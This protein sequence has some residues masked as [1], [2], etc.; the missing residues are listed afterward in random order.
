[1]NGAMRKEFLHWIKQYQG[2]EGSLVILPMK[3]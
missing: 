1:M 2:F 3:V